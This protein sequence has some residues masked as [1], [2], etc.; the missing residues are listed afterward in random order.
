MADEGRELDWNDTIE[1][2]GA[3]FTTIADGEYGFEVKSFRRGRHDGSANL[4]SCNKAILT[5]DI[6]D[7]DG[8]GVGSI[9]HN[10]FLHSKTEGL[11]CQFFRSISR[12][13][14]GEKLK[15]DWNKVIKAT[16]RCRIKNKT[17]PK[18]K[19]P[20]QTVTFCNIDKFLDPPEVEADAAETF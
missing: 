7:D 5:L 3:D 6:F 18:K 9:E 20:T 14:H 15:M 8:K 16:G 10:L 11:V 1:N 2:D 17:E 19:D 4:P 12:R 13:K